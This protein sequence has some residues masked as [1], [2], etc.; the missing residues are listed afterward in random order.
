[1]GFGPL[2]WIGGLVLI[3]V[4]R[5]EGERLGWVGIFTVNVLRYFAFVLPLHGVWSVVLFHEVPTVTLP[6]FMRVV[7]V[8][9][10]VAIEPWVL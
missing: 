5:S 2:G 4:L 1:M 8:R 9:R 10:W 6:F 7:V 3:W